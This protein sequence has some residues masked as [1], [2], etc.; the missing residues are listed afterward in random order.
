[1]TPHIAV[2]TSV[3]LTEKQLHQAQAVV[4]AHLEEIHDAWNRHFG[5]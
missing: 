2:A 5:A 4:E 1:L 3:G